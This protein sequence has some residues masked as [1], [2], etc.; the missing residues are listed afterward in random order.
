MKSLSMVS[1][2]VAAT[3]SKT[4]MLSTRVTSG[5]SMERN[6]QS[7]KFHGTF[8]SV[9]RK[10]QKKKS[11]IRKKKCQKQKP[12]KFFHNGCGTYGCGGG[13]KCEKIPCGRCGRTGL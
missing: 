5:L 1:V 6:H 4:I 11:L 13:S 9:E 2:A 8:L 7:E 3:L 10:L 12:I